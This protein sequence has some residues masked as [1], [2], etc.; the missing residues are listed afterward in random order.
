MVYLGSGPPKMSREWGSETEKRRQSMKGVFATTVPELCSVLWGNAGLRIIP[1]RQI[2]GALT[3]QQLSITRERAVPSSVWQC[4]RQQPV[5]ARRHRGSG[6]AALWAVCTERLGSEAG[7]WTLAASATESCRAKKGGHLGQRAQQVQ[8]IGEIRERLRT[9][10]QGRGT[11]WERTQREIS[12]ELEGM[13]AKTQ[14][15]GNP[16]VWLIF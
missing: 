13:M 11:S 1:Q 15:Y 4:R 5:T 16:Q 3:H 12:P 14:N 2:L 8:N 9:E 10:S 6:V 7:G